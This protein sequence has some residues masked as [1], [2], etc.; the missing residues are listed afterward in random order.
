MRKASDIILLVGAIVSIVCA[1]TF[2]IIGIVF[3]MLGQLPTEE[4]IQAINEG[5]YTTDVPG[6]PEQKALAVKSVL[7]GTGV[8]F[9]I[10]GVM[11]IVNAV[12][13][14]VA[15]AKHS[16]GLYVANIVFGVLSLTEITLVGGIFGLIAN[17]QEANNKPVSE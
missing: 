12:L 15:R 2:L 6:T 5:K 4:I 11:S 9:L 7:T 10:V 17:G 3:A 1:V 13:G 8:F 16:L 14:F